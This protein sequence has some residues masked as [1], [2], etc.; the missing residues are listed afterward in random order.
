MLSNAPL[1]ETPKPDPLR[2]SLVVQFGQV[3][4]GECTAPWVGRT[5]MM[6][7]NST[8]LPQPLSPM[9]ATVSPR[10]SASRYAAPAAEQHVQLVDFHQQ[11]IR[12]SLRGSDCYKSPAVQPKTTCGT[13]RA[14]SQEQIEQQITRTNTQKRWSQAYTFGTDRS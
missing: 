7:F 11:L 2:V 14:R 5:P 10:E 4:P 1:P 6:V 8:V 12:G 3:L 9:I 13:N